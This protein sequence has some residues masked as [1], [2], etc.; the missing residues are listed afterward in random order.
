MRRCSFQIDEFVHPK[1][2]RRSVCYRLNY[3]S[4][5]RSVAGPGGRPIAADSHPINADT[6]LHTLACRSLSNE[7]VNEIQAKVISTVVEQMGVEPR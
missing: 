5:D 6:L 1:T 3:R 4:M 2:G 7:E